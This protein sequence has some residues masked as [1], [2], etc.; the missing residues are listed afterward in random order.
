M[1]D[2]CVFFVAGRPVPVPVPI[3]VIGISFDICYNNKYNIK[4]IID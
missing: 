1:N 2:I 4:F 3:Y